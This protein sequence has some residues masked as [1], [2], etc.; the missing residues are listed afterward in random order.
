MDAIVSSLFHILYF[1]HE[2]RIVKIHQLDYSPGDSHA[3]SDSTVPLVDNPHQPIE[4]SG[5]GMYS[6]LMGIFDLL[7][8][9]TRINAISSSKGPYQKEFF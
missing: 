1:P 6:S 4:N 8:P 7:I 5:V 9:T 2:R 3:T